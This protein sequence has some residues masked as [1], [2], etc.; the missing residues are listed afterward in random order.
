MSARV[1][2]L[3]YWSFVLIS[4][5]ILFPLACIL[6]VVTS[7]FDPRLEVL[8]RFT[9]F[10]GSLYSWCNPFWHV[11]IEGRDRIDPCAVYVMVCNHQSLADIMILFRLMRHFKWVSKSENFRIPLI[12]W[13]MSLNRYIRIERGKMKGNL[14][15]MREA[16]SALRTGSSVMIFPEGT[17][18]PDGALGGFTRGAF[19]LAVR[20]GLQILP[21]V[22]DGTALALPKRGWVLRGSQ[23]IR[24]HVL[25][26][27]GP[28][29]DAARLAEEVHE[30][31][32]RELSRMRAG[33]LEGTSVDAHRGDVPPDGSSTGRFL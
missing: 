14:R 23:R 27:V 25:L 5:A 32:A 1:F 30:Q 22:I 6:R 31:I 19:E 21:L 12:G 11:S 33:L 15:M 20:T 18:S 17:R 24:L 16:E 7:A 10:W 4:S 2:S 26:P 8:H 28:L 29:Q 3:L 9:C 13:N